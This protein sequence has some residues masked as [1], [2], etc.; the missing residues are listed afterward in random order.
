MEISKLISGSNVISV[1]WTF[2]STAVPIV[3]SWATYVATKTQRDIEANQYKLD[4]YDR[5]KNASDSLLAWIKEYG[6]KEEFTPDIIGALHASLKSVAVFF[7]E[8]QTE[9]KLKLDELGVLYAKK[10]DTYFRIKYSKELNINADHLY[11]EYI[12]ENTNTQCCFDELSDMVIDYH[13]LLEESLKVPL[14]PY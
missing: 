11:N 2:L 9:I 10:S 13:V 8:N 12:K 3:V 14:Q 6:S 4:L 7:S 1:I 5:R